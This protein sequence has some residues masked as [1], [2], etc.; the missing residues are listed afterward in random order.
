[1]PEVEIA[2]EPIMADVTAELARL[3]EEMASALASSRGESEAALRAQLAD[4]GE[5]ARRRID[6]AGAAWRAE[7][8]D[9]DVGGV[10]SAHRLPE[11]RAELVGEARAEVHGLR[12]PALRLPRRTVAHAEPEMRSVQLAEHQVDGKRAARAVAAQYNAT[13]WNF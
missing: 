13:P 7:T 9:G 5:I 6:A 10:C 3:R 2:A 1:M 11:Q 8:V 4:A 12:Q